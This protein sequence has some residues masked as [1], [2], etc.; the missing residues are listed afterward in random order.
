MKKMAKSPFFAS[1]SE[2]LEAKPAWQFIS[3]VAI[4]WHR[5]PFTRCHSDFFVEVAVK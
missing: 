5:L 2:R 4:F 3:L 1:G